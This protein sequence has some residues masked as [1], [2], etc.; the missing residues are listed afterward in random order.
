MDSK[1]LENKKYLKSQSIHDLHSHFN[2]IKKENKLLQIEEKINFENVW[3]D[4]KLESNLLLE[5]VESFDLLNHGKKRIKMKNV[6][7]KKMLQKD[8][9]LIVMRK[10]RAIKK[11]MKRIMIPLWLKI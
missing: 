1:K 6:N 8:M 10:M 4:K 2:I 5:S 3:K 9:H 7:N 11:R